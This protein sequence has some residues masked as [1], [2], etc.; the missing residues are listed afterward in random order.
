MTDQ[1]PITLPPELI[2]E[3]I[4]EA[5]HNEKMFPQAAILAAC[6][7]ADQELEV[8]LKCLAE[9][10]G[11]GFALELQ[12]WRRPQPPS[13]KEQALALVNSKGPYLNDDEIETIRKALEA[14]PE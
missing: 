5:N 11:G 3:W 6:W 2:E 13:L 4:K 14:L 8:C 12:R 10:R 7:G 9:I 1:H